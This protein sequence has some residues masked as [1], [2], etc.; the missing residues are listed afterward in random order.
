[1]S[2]GENANT[3]LWCLSLYNNYTIMIAHNGD[4]SRLLEFSKTIN[5]PFFHTMFFLCEIQHINYGVNYLRSVVL[6][7]YRNI[8]RDEEAL[9]HV[10]VIQ[11]YAALW[12]WRNLL[13]RFV[14]H[15]FKNRQVNR[16]IRGRN[17]AHWDS[18][19]T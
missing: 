4:N 3:L 7:L 17:L 6:L 10:L 1:M 11:L 15:V 13:K 12:K 5:V 18:W 9:Y 14:W 16:K 2:T 8:D 19:V